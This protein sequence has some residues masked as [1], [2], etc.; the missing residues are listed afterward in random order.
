MTSATHTAPF[1]RKPL[2]KRFGNLDRVLHALEAR[3]L[4]GIEA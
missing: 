2:L 3:G 4:D 1:P